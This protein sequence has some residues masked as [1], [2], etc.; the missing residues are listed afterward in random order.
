[1]GLYRYTRLPFGIASAPAVFQR[2]MEHILQG[3]PQ[4]VIYL[5]DLLI[6]EQNEAE[7]L[8]VLRQ[9]LERLRQ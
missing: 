8:Q 1:M 5:D 9:V 3:I 6:T 4:V 2:I 7:H